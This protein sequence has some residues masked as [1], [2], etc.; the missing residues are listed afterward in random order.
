MEAIG[1]A[2]GPYRTPAQ[3]LA[4]VVERFHRDRDCWL[5]TAHPRTGPYVVPLSFVMVESLALLATAEPRRV[6]HNIR[7]MPR[8]VIVLGG[9]GDAIRANGICEVVAFDAIA[10]DLRTAY[11]EKA[12]WDPGH[13]DTPFVAL[14]LRLVEVWCSRS[15][16]EESDRVVWRAG[17]PTPW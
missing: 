5:A 1:D 7:A 6:V 14:L 4:G 10:S 8:A 13:Q 17:D 11:V 2:T 15:P 16:V 3:R 9:Y 12:G